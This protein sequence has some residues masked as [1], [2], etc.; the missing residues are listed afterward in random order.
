M[1]ERE[2]T[3]E[4][5]SQ[6]TDSSLHSSTMKYLNDNSVNFSTC[7]W[8]C[9]IVLSVSVSGTMWNNKAFGL[10]ARLRNKRMN[11]MRLK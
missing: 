7:V 10:S 4:G 8:V 6:L 11:K 1:E 3:R 5:D 2:R 9:L